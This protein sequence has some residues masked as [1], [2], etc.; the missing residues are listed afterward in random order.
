MSSSFRL[1]ARRPVIFLCDAARSKRSV[2]SRSADDDA[3]AA[4]MLVDIRG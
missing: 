4:A 2:S 3:G 1:Q